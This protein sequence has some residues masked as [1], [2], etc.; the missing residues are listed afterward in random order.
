MWFIIEDLGLM[1]PKS[2]T[3]AFK[4][5]LS[6]AGFSELTVPDFLFFEM[7]FRPFAVKDLHLMKS[8]SLT[9]TFKH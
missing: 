5:Y 2:V 1:K 8:K 3:L 7:A 6:D 9:R 4:H